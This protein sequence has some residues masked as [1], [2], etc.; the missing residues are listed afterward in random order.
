[1]SIQTIKLT[2]S[3]GVALNYFNAIASQPWAM[4]LYSGNAIHRYNRFDIIVADPITTLET[5]NNVTQINRK[6][7][8]IRSKLDPF[9]LLK[10]ELKYLNLVFEVNSDLPFQGG[11]LGIWGYDLARRTEILPEQAEKELSFPDMAI[12][13]YLWAL[14][15]DHHK[16]IVTLL[17]YQNVKKRL[18]WLE[19]QIKTPTK[20]FKMCESFQSNMSKQQYHHK[21]S[22]IHQYLRE[23]D[24][25]QINLAQRFKAKY[26]GN[27]WDAFL[28][29][30]QNNH[31]PF[32]AFIRLEQN[33]VISVSPERFLWLHND[34]IQTRP[35]KGTLPRLKDAQEDQEQI[36]RLQSST[37][38][39][40][41]NVMIVDLLRNDIGK[42]AIPGTIMVPELCGVE[43]FLAIHHL[44]STIVAQ[45]PSHYHATDLLRA[46]FPGG[47]I[48]GAP[49]IR[50]MEIIDELEPH[51]R[52][53][54]C[55]A[56]GYI[57]F[58]RT[59]DTNIN[60][61]TLLTENE[62]LYCWAGGGIVVDSTAEKEYQEIFDKLSRILPVLENN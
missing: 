52:H 17:S 60:I 36:K 48:T 20:E 59:M 24:C 15:V 3:L 33:C 28:K 47:S 34:S 5:R 31:A 44:V 4:L 35:I 61:R 41:E 49:K 18:F 53:S 38:D 21:I 19:N 22:Q 10:N 25:Y 37:K 7:E 50:S 27:E 45:L 16:K 26:Q 62:Y 2:Y 40:A 6:N 58:C 1:M 51:R 43:S 30:N 57:S 54:Y 42:V 13:V 23:G 56:I 39:R 46:C 12:G 32:S 8:K 29:L 9:E 14:I 11:A 55:G